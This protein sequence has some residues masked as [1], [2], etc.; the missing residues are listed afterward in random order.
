M[1]TFSI[2][3]ALLVVSFSAMADG[4]TYQY[5]QV[6]SS[7]L[8]RAQVEAQT[9]AAAVRGELVS[10]EL[11]YAAP[12]QGISLSRSEI[13]AELSAARAKNELP[14]GEFAFGAQSQG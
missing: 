2:A 14:H 6:M 3:A 8:T 5:P 4:A 10:G 11:G 7:N 12:A 1:K 13:S 9:A